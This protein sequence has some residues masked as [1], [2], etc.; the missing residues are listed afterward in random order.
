M[1]KVAADAIGT[2][3]DGMKGAARLCLVFGVSVDAT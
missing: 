1:H 2:E 3:A